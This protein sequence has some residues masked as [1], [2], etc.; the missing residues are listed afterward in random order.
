MTGWSL[1]TVRRED[2]TTAAAVRRDD[3]RYVIP[4]VLRGYPGLREALDNWDTVAE[5]LR[6]INP[7][8]MSTVDADELLSL[9]Y[10][11]KVLCVGA[12][13][14]DHIAEMGVTEVPEGVDPFFFAVPPTTSLIG[15][16][17]TVILGRSED[18][19][20]DWE[21]ELAIVIGRRAVDVEPSE[22]WDYIAGYACFN[23]ITARGLM[24]RTDPIAF[25]F[26]WDWVA[27][28]GRDTYSPLGAV[29]PSWLIDDPQNL[30]IRCYVNDVLKQDGTTSNL[31][32]GIAE[33]VS[34]ASKSWTLEPGD[35]IASGTPAGVGNSKGEQL[36]DGDSVRVEIDGLA[37]LSNGILLEAPVASGRL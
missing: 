22:A 7:D 35:V 18:H 32:V 25:P 6:G 1:T 5:A 28:K 10:P 17:G 3:G 16:G 21:A 26:T 15:N 20:P 23:D 9:Q 19:R 27:S 12:N 31:I 37:S 11:H 34:A 4:E 2:G 29:T 33:L 24:R 8:T 30:G 36:R 14:K 13:Y